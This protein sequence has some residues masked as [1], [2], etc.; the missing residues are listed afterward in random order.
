MEREASF[1]YQTLTVAEDSASNIL[2]VNG[3]LIHLSPIEIPASYKVFSDKLHLP[4]KVIE[5]SE[6]SKLSASMSR[7]VILLKKSKKSVRP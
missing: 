4:R 6:L 7:L 2:F 5:L 3:T 1:R